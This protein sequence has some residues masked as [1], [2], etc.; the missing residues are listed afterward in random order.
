MNDVNA[1][2][3]CRPDVLLVIDD[4]SEV[5]GGVQGLLQSPGCVVH[6]TSSPIEG[7]KSYETPWRGIRLLLSDSLA[8]TLR[9]D[10]VVGYLQRVNPT[11]RV[12]FI[13]D[14]NGD[15]EKK[16]FDE[17]LRD[18]L[19]QPLVVLRESYSLFGLAFGG[20]GSASARQR[21]QQRSTV[22]KP[23]GALSRCIGGAV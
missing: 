14:H 11:V 17:R 16:T 21:E 2:N 6:A 1:A 22:A 18:F 9:D 12:A 10:E 7:I 23:R 19:Q 13:S 15:G 5:L 4:A 20:G 8:Q 3:S